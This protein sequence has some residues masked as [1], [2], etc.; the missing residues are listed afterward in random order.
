MVEVAVGDVVVPGDDVRHVTDADQ[1]QVGL[2]FTWQHRS[3]LNSNNDWWALLRVRLFFYIAKLHCSWKF[4]CGFFIW[5]MAYCTSLFIYRLFWVLASGGK[6]KTW[7]RSSPVF[8]AGTKWF[9]SLIC[10]IYLSL[11]LLITTSLVFFSLFLS[12]IDHQFNY[13]KLI[14]KYAS[15]TFDDSLPFCSLCYAIIILKVSKLALLSI[16]NTH[17]KCS[18]K[19]KSISI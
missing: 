1:K 3:Y 6:E 9:C 14:F 10:L 15:Y 17:G 2:L 7:G 13:F 8:C 12:L 16:N 11:S 4:D 18:S 19:S 5:D